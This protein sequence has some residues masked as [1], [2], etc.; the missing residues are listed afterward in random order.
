[1]KSMYI[2]T[3][4]AKPHPP[5]SALAAIEQNTSSESTAAKRRFA[6]RP[7]R[8]FCVGANTFADSWRQNL[9]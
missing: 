8:I 2:P 1:M 5:L 3:Y 9:Q 7:S 6:P 4:S